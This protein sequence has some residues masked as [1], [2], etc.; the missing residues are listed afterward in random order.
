M[1]VELV[2]YLDGKFDVSGEITLPARKLFDICRALPA[3]AVLSFEI[4]NDRALIKSGK[5]RFTLSS[6]PPQEYPVID[7]SDPIAAF[8]IKQNTL[9]SLLEN[10]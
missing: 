2:V 10:T 5:S 4:K 6:L 8:Q 1:E 9:E 7:I 3:E